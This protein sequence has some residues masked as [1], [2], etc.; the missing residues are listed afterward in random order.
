MA[1]S[2][3][4]AAR[5]AALSGTGPTSE[6]PAEQWP[7]ATSK[8]GLFGEVLYVGVFVALLSTA[9]VTAPLA[10]ALGVRHLRRYV[11]G[12]SSGF[13]QVV[14]DM[15]GNLARGLLVGVAAIAALLLLAFDIAV[16]RDRI[17]P[18][19]PLVEVAGWLGLMALCLG[20]TTA[21]GLWSPE[22]GWRAAFRAC[23]PAWRHD[24][25]GLLYLLAA[26]ALVPL[27]TWQLLPLVVPAL[28]CLALAVVAIPERRRVIA[29]N[30]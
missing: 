2:A 22:L 23:V 9:L 29:P 17:M 1:R 5:R 19:A 7:G 18:G 3:D 16:A 6:D 26:I 11:R 15:S 4:R 24:P 30:S 25:V 27:L 8:F 13:A 21:A 12:E 14:A 28:G 20:V 10:F